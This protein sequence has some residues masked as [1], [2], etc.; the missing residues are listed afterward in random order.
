MHIKDEQN[1]STFG[2]IKIEK[3]K[4]HYDKNPVLKDNIDINKVLVPN[5][6]SPG[7]ENIKSLLVTKVMVIKIV[8]C[9]CFF[10]K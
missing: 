7:K 10:H 1:N 3:H 6:V 5:K 4:F 2:D 8:H 9:I